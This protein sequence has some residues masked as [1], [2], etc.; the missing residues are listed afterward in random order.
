MAAVLQTTI[1]VGETA[2][3]TSSWVGETAVT[4]LVP[5]GVG[6]EADV[7]VRVESPYRN[8]PLRF[9]YD[10]PNIT[11]FDQENMP[12]TGGKA[13]TLTGTDFGTSSYS[14]RGRF[15]G[16]AAAATDWFSDSS[17]T[18][19]SAPGMGPS[20][21]VALTVGRSV[22][23][24]TG[25]ATFDQPSFSSAVAANAPTSGSR[26]SFVVG[27][28]Y[29]SWSFTQRA[30][31][32][33]TACMSTSWVSTSSL[34]CKISTGAG[35]KKAV[36]VTVSGLLGTGAAAMSYDSAVALSAHNVPLAGISVINVTG[37]AFGWY[38][39]SI[40]AR[41]GQTA[42]PSTSWLSDTSIT[43]G[44]PRGFLSSH[45]IVITA[46]GMVHT[47]TAA[48]SYDLVSLASVS[49]GNGP[50]TGNTYVTVIGANMGSFDVS[51][52]VRIGGTACSATT[53]MSDTGIACMIPQNTSIFDQSKPIVVTVGGAVATMSRAF[54]YDP[55]PQVARKGMANIKATLGLSG[56]VRRKL[57]SCRDTLPI[58]EMMH[59]LVILL[60]QKQVSA[61]RMS[62]PETLEISLDAHSNDA[63]QDVATIT[64]DAS[65][66]Q[67][68]KTL[69]VVMS[70]FKVDL[71]S[72]PIAS[73]L[74]S[75]HP[76]FY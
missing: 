71:V 33:G 36:A 4:C 6:A 43:L 55:A 66:L 10:A 26:V 59:R 48:V 41:I 24:A 65:M 20:H 52:R 34:V 45:H 1:Y 42:C 16:T 2:C 72:S 38:D 57:F 27:A 53:W 47:S 64:Q 37:G 23:T 12:T 21:T 56:L 3:Q 76:F 62:A 18:C 51:P 22:C 14:V 17:V 31:L 60:F 25:A 35:T 40:R 58:H 73:S 49:P 8:F 63:S 75:L 9:S 61:I 15:G 11:S 28:N 46:E 70:D 54:D 32:G 74:P 50:S 44:V 5:P 67:I 19:S 13:V 7:R 30:R 68:R 29:G 69:A 39:S